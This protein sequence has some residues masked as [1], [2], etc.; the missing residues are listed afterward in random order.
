MAP[1][2]FVLTDDHPADTPAAMLDV[3]RLL[4]IGGTSLAPH[5]ERHQ[6]LPLERACRSNSDAE[7]RVTGFAEPPQIT[8]TGAYQAYLV[9]CWQGAGSADYR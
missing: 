4:G 3:S 2:Q 6:R 8:L 9:E 1:V 5:G 7:L